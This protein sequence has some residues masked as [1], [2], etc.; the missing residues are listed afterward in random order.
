MPAALAALA[1]AA[2]AQRSTAPCRAAT[3]AMARPIDLLAR[4]TGRGGS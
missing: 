1:L 4:A 2:G 3:G